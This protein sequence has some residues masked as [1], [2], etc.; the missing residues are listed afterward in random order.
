MIQY[1]RPVSH[2]HRKFDRNMMINQLDWGIYRP[3]IYPIFWQIMANPHSSRHVERRSGSENHH[4]WFPQS[5]IEKIS[6]PPPPVPP[7]TTSR[8]TPSPLRN[9]PSY[10]LNGCDKAGMI[11]GQIF[12]WFQ[13]QKP[14][15]MGPQAINHIP[16]HSGQL[17][18]FVPLLLCVWRFW[19]QIQPISL[20]HTGSAALC[21]QLLSGYLS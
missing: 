3:M 13:T 2:K 19:S 1:W 17:I 20:K 18:G 10:A 11:G 21:F 12:V 8:A 6:P 9:V 15:E 14:S 7:N 5:S 4:G 16:C